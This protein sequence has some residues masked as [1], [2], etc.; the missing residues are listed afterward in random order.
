MPAPLTVAEFVECVKKS[1]VLE[2]DRLETYL[3]D[4]P[5]AA[6]A[7]STP[8]QLAEAMIRDG[9]LTRFQAEQFLQGK[10]RHF[11]ISGKY[12]LLER[13]GSGGM[14]S[15]FLCEHLV[16][17]RRVAIKVLPQAQAGDSAALERFHREARAVAKLHHPNIIG[18]YDIDRDGKMHFLVMEY[19]EG[20]NL[21]DL[22]KKHG[23]LDIVRACHYVAQA[24][25]G[26]QHA[27]EAGLVHRD[28]KPANL[29]LDRSGT[30]KVLDLGLAR[31]FHDE[32]DNLTQ[33]Y[34][35]AVL[36]TA[37]YLAPE[38][39]TDSHGVDIRAD[40]YSLG[41]T[42]YYLLAGNSPFQKGTVVQKLLWHQMR[43]P[44]PIR[45][46]RPEV[47]EELAAVLDRML[48]KDPAQRYQTP[49]EVIAAL[50]PWL[51]SPVPPPAAEEMPQ[52]C[53][54]ARGEEDRD[55]GP[56]TRMK[57]M[58]PLTALHIGPGGQS[59]VSSLTPFGSSS[60]SQTPRPQ[61]L[62]ETSS[63]TG[64]AQTLSGTP[65]PVKAPKPRWRPLLLILAGV[66]AAGA[67][68]AVWW[69]ARGHRGPPPISSPNSAPEDL[70]GLPRQES[71]SSPT[72]PHPAGVAPAPVQVAAQAGPARLI[73]T[74]TG[75]P[76]TF[77]TLRDALIKARPGD[78]LMVR[79][80][81]LEEPLWLG[82]DGPSGKDLVIEG[83][84]P[85]GEP[86]IW[87]IPEDF[88][89]GRALVELTGTQGL[90]LSGFVLEGEGRVD[91]LATL[92]GPCPGL[93]LSDLQFRG[94]RRGAIRVANCTGTKERPVRL[95]GLLTFGG[96]ESEAALV[97]EANPDQLNRDLAVDD[98]RLTG[99][100]QEVVRIQGP[101]A[102]VDFFH[103][104]LFQA[105]KGFLFQKVTPSP[106]LRLA[107]RA[108]TLAHLKQGLHFESVPL[109]EGDNQLVV[110]KDLFLQV[111][112]MA[113][114]DGLTFDPKD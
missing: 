59:P 55:G 28:I 91:Y 105:E 17:R 102:E 41:V 79:E 114:V 57:V 97:F 77:R 83:A 49:S 64:L 76:N 34:E 10:W 69:W 109:A 5:E 37:D 18:A 42:F 101:L 3:R 58:A 9:L 25:Q 61:S 38:Q 85:S 65:P 96:P 35:E 89:T 68:G 46:L 19:V 104:R 13:L 98:C 72:T 52:L 20:T 36:G 112:K 94:F 87:K 63:S 110:Q 111:S 81:T 31:F 60:G 23:P 54:A 8:R 78:H 107:L 33:K 15:V 32:K 6:A 26:L 48:A 47:S 7:D 70:A 86:V 100:Y 1:D 22:I 66:M 4:C 29:L 95:R 106:R 108:N 27:H 67:V 45:E 82:G 92:S 30:I 53:P 62:F 90:R 80:E 50:V 43:Q 99:P 93:K 51:Q 14:G 12:K 84:A 75:A 16:M 73:V 113:V 44:Q 88:P 40:I 103:N 56:N 2:G 11:V 24:A 21:Q 74:D 39:A 71:A